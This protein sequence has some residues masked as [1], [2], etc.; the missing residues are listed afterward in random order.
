MIVQ[1]SENSQTN[2]ANK[3]KPVTATRSSEHVTVGGMQ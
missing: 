3:Q 2:S 1:I